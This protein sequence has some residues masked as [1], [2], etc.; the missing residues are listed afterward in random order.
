MKSS[1]SLQ[2]FEIGGLGVWASFQ[3]AEHA[4]DNGDDGGQRIGDEQRSH[5]RAANDDQFRRLHEHE[6]LA[7]LHQVAADHGT[8][9]N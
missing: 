4:L 8:D 6:Q 9:D 5:R 2:R 3:D 7:V 1:L